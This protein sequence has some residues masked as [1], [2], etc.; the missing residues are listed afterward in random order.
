MLTSKA[1]LLAH[2]SLAT[3]A[4]VYALLALDPASSAITKSNYIGLLV[5]ERPMGMGGA[6]TA[7]SD[8]PSGLYYNPAG[9]VYSHAPNLS[10]SVNAFH[11]SQTRY[12]DAL[13]AAD[14]ERNSQEL[15]PNY[16]GTTQPLGPFTVGLSYAV[17]QTLQEEQAQTFDRLG[18]EDVEYLSVNVDNADT[19]TK[20]GPSI[21]YEVN[22]RLALGGTLYGHLRERKTITTQVL[23]VGEESKLEASDH[24]EPDRQYEVRNTYRTTEELGFT[25]ILGAMLTPIDSVSLGASIRGTQILSTTNSQQRLCHGAQDPRVEGEYEDSSLCEPGQV[26]FHDLQEDHVRGAYPIETKLGV[27]WFPSSRLLLTADVMHYTS[28][29]GRKQIVNVASGGEYY[30]NPDWAIR[31][32]GHTNFSNTPGLV[33]FDHQIDRYRFT[34]S[35]TR[36]SRNSSVS[37][38]FNAGYGS[39]E[40]RIVEGAGIQDVTTR[41]L[42]LFLATSYSY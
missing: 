15:L 9:I 6:Y 38:G 19:M 23:H 3:A 30:L 40:A 21:A 16:F 5:G 22:D 2:R 7:V 25:W 27:A 37:V 14:W 12:A 20:G 28:A 39:G 18:N 42:T 1:R 35:L 26:G 4:S 36:F 32:G 31:I 17:P 29:E 13:G 33:D 24:P 8:G 10:A 41:S 34:G 11:S